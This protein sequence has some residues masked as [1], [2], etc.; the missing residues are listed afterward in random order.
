[1]KFCLRNLSKPGWHASM[2]LQDAPR[3]KALGEGGS[4]GEA[5]E[6]GGQLRAGRPGKCWAGHWPKMAKV[7]LALLGRMCNYGRARREDWAKYGRGHVRKYGKRMV[8]HVGARADTLNQTL[9]FWKLPVTILCCF[10]NSLL[11]YFAVLETPSY[12]TLRF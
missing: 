5:R 3:P 2:P 1:M 4:G 11:P 8:W 12:H 6:G 10:R 7:W 9:R